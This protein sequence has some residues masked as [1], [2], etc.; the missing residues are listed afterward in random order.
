MEVSDKLSQQIDTKA[1]FV[2]LSHKSFT[3][4]FSNIDGELWNK[5]LMFL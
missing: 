5:S 2:A 4:G 1:H 3:A